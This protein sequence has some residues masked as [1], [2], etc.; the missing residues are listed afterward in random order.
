MEINRP[1][2]LNN[3][4]NVK[5]VFCVC[6]FR[7]DIKI[8]YPVW[9]KAVFSVTAMPKT[10]NMFF[11]YLFWFRLLHTQVFVQYNLFEAVLVIFFSIN[12][13]LQLLLLNILFTVVPPELWGHQELKI[14]LRNTGTILCW[15]GIMLLWTSIVMCPCRDWKSCSHCCEE[16]SAPSWMW[17]LEIL[18]WL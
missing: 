18:Q 3:I 14:F 4:G 7:Q 17:N 16:T 1:T 15:F 8:M 2:P 10:V 5:K 13:W 11:W 12:H 9:K 6:V